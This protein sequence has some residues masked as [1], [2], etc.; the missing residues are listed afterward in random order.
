MKSSYLRE[1]WPSLK[2]PYGEKGIQQYQALDLN[3]GTYCV[4]AGDHNI[5]EESEQ[6]HWEV[7]KP[8]IILSQVDTLKH[9]SHFSFL[10]FLFELLSMLE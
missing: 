1:V 6:K 7:V 4:K 10:V 9:S 2:V 3:H 8:K 5:E